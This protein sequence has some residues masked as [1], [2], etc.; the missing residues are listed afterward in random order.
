MTFCSKS[1]SPLLS[2]GRVLLVLLTAALC[3]S[4][5]YSQSA[6]QLKGRIETDPGAGLL[7]GNICLSKLPQQ[8]T[9]SFLLNRGLNIRE[10]KEAASDQPLK[11]LGY[12]NATNIGDATRYTVGGSIGVEPGKSTATCTKSLSGVSKHIVQRHIAGKGAKG[13]SRTRT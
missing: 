11:H 5:A 3:S 6:P 7:R 9:V 8:Q 4:I 12:Y 13:W 10:L 1:D 2:F